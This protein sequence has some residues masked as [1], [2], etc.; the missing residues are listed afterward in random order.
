MI[1]LEPK[2]NWILFDKCKPPADLCLDT[3]YLIFLR[4]DDHN[5]GSTWTYSVDI[6]TAYG[7]Y[8]DDFWDT[9]T[10]WKEG[11][12]VEVIAYAELPYGQKEEE[13]VRTDA[14]VED[15]TLKDLN[16]MKE[17]FGF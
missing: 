1:K 12:R 4:E 3:Q 17:R 9:E 7:S 6:A 11:Q 10:D 5:N 15:P 8:L 13:L 14:L 16:N 2:I